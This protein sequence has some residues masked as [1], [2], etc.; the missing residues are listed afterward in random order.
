MISSPLLLSTSVRNNLRIYTSTHF[1][2]PPL[3]L[4]NLP[5]K[6]LYKILCVTLWKEMTALYLN[7]RLIKQLQIL[8]Q[9]TITGCYLNPV[10]GFWG[11]IHMFTAY[12]VKCVYFPFSRDDSHLRV[13]NSGCP[14]E[15]NAPSFGGLK[16]RCL[17]LERD[18]Y[19]SCHWLRIFLFNMYRIYQNIIFT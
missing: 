11:N 17:S 5:S 18:Y 8:L 7:Q 9:I 3:A 4:C 6:F 10:R 19:D 1:F 14:L 16:A 15:K 12:V 2:L 13:R